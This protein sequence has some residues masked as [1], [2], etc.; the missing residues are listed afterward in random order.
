MEQVKITKRTDLDGAVRLSNLMKQ[1]SVNIL[2][3]INFIQ[4]NRLALKQLLTN[5]D[6]ETRAFESTIFKQFFQMHYNKE[7]SHLK[8]F[9][10][11]PGTLRA[12]FQLQYLMDVVNEG[13]DETKK[14]KDFDQSTN[15]TPKNKSNMFSLNIEMDE[16]TANKGGLSEFNT[17]EAGEDYPKRQHFSMLK[18]KIATIQKNFFETESVMRLQEHFFKTHKNNLFKQLGLDIHDYY[19][20]DNLTIA[21]YEKYTKN[22]TKEEF[23]MIN[24]EF[25]L[26]NETVEEKACYSMLDL[27][28]VYLHTFLYVLNYYGLAQTSPDYSKSLGLPKSLSGILQ[29]ASPAAAIFFGVFINV[30]TKKKYKYPY[31]L[32]LGMLF[33]GNLFYY[34]AETFKS[35]KALALTLLILG[36]MIFGSGGSRLMTRKFVAI[37]VPTQYQS[38]YS[39]YLVGFSA[40]GITLG[41]GISS[42]VEFVNRTTVL[43]TDLDK[44]NI[45][46][47][48]FFFVW[49]FLFFFFMF[50]FKG[51]DVEVEKEHIKME[52]GERKLKEKFHNLQDYYN[53]FESKS[54]AKNLNLLQ[55]N[56]VNFTT[57]GLFVPQNDQI[58][59]LTF[60]DHFKAVEPNTIYK[61]ESQG[62]GNQLKVL[63]PNNMTV[64]SLWCFLVFKIIQEAYFTE[65]PQMVDEFYGYQSQFVGWL[66]LGFTLIGVPTAL[67]TGWATKKYED[68][69]IL[70]IGFII[71]IFACAAKINYGFDKPMPQA[72]YFIASAVLFMASL[73]GE[74]AAI[75]ILAKVISPSLK[76]GFLNAGLL[77]G[78]ADTVGRALGNSSMTLFASISGR[79]ATCFY[80]YISFLVLLLIT[81]VFNM[82]FY[83][84]IKKYSI[85]TIHIRKEEERLLR[86]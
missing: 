4:L 43:G 24:L 65:Q 67:G 16:N 44:F 58:K 66:M 49:M 13:L 40:L 86:E 77:A 55:K 20:F 33:V 85:I 34:L 21:A 80:M 76:L 68:R 22:Q 75:S 3:M 78:T 53:N 14:R 25:T 83:K 46:A 48:I 7:N 52:K 12:Y 23:I 70:L 61:D 26:E 8:H 27:G 36:R 73:I 18:D 54:M 32:C 31:L 59:S 28:L 35:N 11:H 81:F 9:L 72:Q 29:A 64:Y 79:D 1:S 84:K 69:K 82:I 57:S 10:E 47:F 51:Y 15:S 17:N 56:Q 30:I 6:K 19:H 39:T 50:F 38:K 74:A 42:M 5:I 63:F 37:N 45:L 41:P 62:V 2:N 60:K 71:Y